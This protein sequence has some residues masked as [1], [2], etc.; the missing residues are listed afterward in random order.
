MSDVADDMMIEHPDKKKR[1]AMQKRTRAADDR[2]RF[3]LRF[4]TRRSIINKSNPL[5]VLEFQ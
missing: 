3:K 1:L 4:I 2:E 5:S